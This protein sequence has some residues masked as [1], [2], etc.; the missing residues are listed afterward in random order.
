MG[1]NS[2]LGCGWALVCGQP[3]ERIPPLRAISSYYF[4]ETDPGIADC[5]LGN[6]DKSLGRKDGHQLSA[7]T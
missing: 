1:G 6:I 2:A 5:D 3:A 7:D 4:S